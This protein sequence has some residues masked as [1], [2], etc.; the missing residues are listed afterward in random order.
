MKTGK[1]V[2]L[3]F[4]AKIIGYRIR[5][6]GLMKNEEIIKKGSHFCCSNHIQG[7]K[8]TLEEQAESKIVKNCK[9]NK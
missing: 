7:S 9:V 2:A 4:S 5:K 1:Q 3:K 8:K 6:K